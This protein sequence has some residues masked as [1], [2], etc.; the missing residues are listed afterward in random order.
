MGDLATLGLTLL[1]GF[2]LLQVVRIA[3]SLR[4]S[5]PLR[6]CSL[7]A[8]IGGLTLLLAVAGF[9]SMNEFGPGAVA[10]NTLPFLLGIAGLSFWVWGRFAWR[11]KRESKIGPRCPKCRYD[12]AGLANPAACPE[13]GRSLLNVPQG[14]LYKPRIRRWATRTGMVTLLLAIAFPVWLSSRDRG[15]IALV[16]SSVL[17][18]LATS[19]HFDEEA[20]AELHERHLQLANVDPSWTLAMM[21]AVADDYDKRNMAIFARGWTRFYELYQPAIDEPNRQT[22]RD[23]TVSSSIGKRYVAA[24]LMQV[25]GV[26]PAP[27]RLTLLPPLLD[28]ADLG[29]RIAAIRALALEQAWPLDDLIAYSRTHTDP[30]SL[31]E[32]GN[33]L[34]GYKEPKAL[35]RR[36][37][38]AADPT[39]KYATSTGTTLLILA[40]RRAADEG[41][42]TDLESLARGGMIPPTSQY[43][44]GSTNAA[45]EYARLYQGLVDAALGG[46]V[47][48][49]G[50]LAPDAK[51]QPVD[52]VTTA[53]CRRC[54][55]SLCT[56]GPSICHARPIIL[57]IIDN[58][59]ANTTDAAEAAALKALRNQIVPESPPDASPGK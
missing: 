4:K 15:L 24:T 33:A 32:I 9:V 54:V 38:I 52:P 45:S 5:R 28:D 30:S 29:V 25:A 53:W 21:N 58:R 12:L 10:G 57:A 18:R 17:L 27:D 20:I 19:E 46:P 50:K 13:C 37:E 2:L 6:V 55:V 40:L 11:F 56:P 26:M 35:E 23:W 16:P 3:P 42:V 22:L 1:A 14:R 44:S 51:P 47:R 36:I 8:G 34:Y 7:I 43:L 31:F 39:N 49:G 48:P 59:I 41:V